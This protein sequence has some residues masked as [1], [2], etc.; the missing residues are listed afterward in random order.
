M[1]WCVL[2]SP[3]TEV[4]EEVKKERLGGT[5]GIQPATWLQR[6]RRLGPPVRTGCFVPRR[7][8]YLVLWWKRPPK[9][10]AAAKAGLPWWRK[11]DRKTKQVQGSSL[12]FLVHASTSDSVWLRLSCY[13]GRCSE[14]EAC[15]APCRGRGRHMPKLC[16][17]EQIRHIFVSCTLLLL[18]LL[19]QL[20]HSIPANG[21]TF[22]DLCNFIMSFRIMSGRDI[23]KWI[24]F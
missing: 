17:T 13:G 7:A 3:M 12:S 2:S 24:H 23:Q 9:N 1:P 20:P 10:C 15:W 16:I 4:G 22:K 21:A 8:I 18:M 11:E 6:H 14:R 19:C 5:E